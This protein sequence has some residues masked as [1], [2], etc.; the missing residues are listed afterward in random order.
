MDASNVEESVRVDDA[1]KKILTCA[2]TEIMAEMGKIYQDAKCP[3]GLQISTEDI[4]KD[5][6]KGTNDS[7][8]DKI[9][10]DGTYNG[11][12]SEAGLEDDLLWQVVRE[13]KK[14]H[15]QV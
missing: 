3:T 14:C 2:R 12:D 15:V 6:D 4:E 9:K 11:E 1:S 7:A 13:I 5:L 8:D 10:Y